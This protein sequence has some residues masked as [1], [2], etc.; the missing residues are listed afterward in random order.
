M[1]KAAKFVIG[2]VLVV[3]LLPCF[4]TCYYRGVQRYTLTDS[5]YSGFFGWMTDTSWA[6]SYSERNFAKVSVGMTKDEVQNIMGEPVWSPNP[7]YWGY[8]WSPSSSHYHQRGFVFTP[9]GSVTRIVKGF[10]FD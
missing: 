1:Y 10:Y 5:L 4:V 9:S 2:F 6:E 3:C 7:N 8:T